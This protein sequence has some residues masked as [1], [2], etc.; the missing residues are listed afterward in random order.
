M[1]RDRAKASIYIILLTLCKNNDKT[2]HDFCILLITDLPPMGPKSV[3]VCG[4]CCLPDSNWKEFALGNKFSRIA[5]ATPKDCD[6][7]NCNVVMQLGCLFTINCCQCCG[8]T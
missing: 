3:S 8:I 5:I 4:S 7:M 1:G 6:Q 2:K